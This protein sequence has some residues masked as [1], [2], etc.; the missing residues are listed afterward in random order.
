MPLVLD[1]NG[2]D[3]PRDIVHRAVQTLAEGGLVAFPT[4]TVYGLAASA[5]NDQAVR[6]LHEVKGRRDDQSFALAVRSAEDAFDYAP[7]MSPLAIRLA[8]RCWPGPL[9]L[10]VDDE[11][12]DSLV[13]RL[14][15]S[16]QKLVVRNGSLGLRVPAHVLILNVLRLAV[17]PLALT[18][19]NR[20]GEPEAVTADDV[21]A[22]LG[23]DVSL[24]LDDGRCKFGQPSSVVRVQGRK[25]EVLRKG[26][27]VESTL[28][29]LASYILLVVCTGNTC[30][31]PMA[32]ALMRKRIAERLGCDV[33]GLEEK[34]LMVMSAGIAAMAGGRAAPEAIQTI[35]AWGADL[36]NH[37]SQPLSDRLVRFADTILTMTRGHR[38]AILSQWPEAAERTQL[39]SAKQQ[40]IAD[41]IGGPLE[42]YRRCAEQID[43]QIASWIEHFDLA[44]L[45]ESSPRVETEN[46]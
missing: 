33:E 19:A 18:S 26:V 14:P 21:A 41:P 24:I 6:K 7:Q 5:V 13:R 8:R 15:L 40:D 32:E 23:G 27:I 44:T 2:S 29:R 20:T 16:V 43:Q 17:G 22:S 11:H 38:E 3:D 45:P 42:L 30:R 10:V 12:P 37:E 46:P 34:G 4:E 31:S 9:T 25:Y 28:R 1:I 36:S 35:Q 39:L